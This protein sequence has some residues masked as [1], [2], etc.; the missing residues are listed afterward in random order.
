MKNLTEKIKEIIKKNDL[1]QKNDHI[2][3]GVSGGP[4]SV[5]L[6][7]ILLTLS[8]EIDFTLSAVH[9]N[10]KYRPGAAEEDEA[11]VRTFCEKA[12]VPLKVVCE[13]MLE[14]AKAQNLTPEEAGRKIRYKAFMDEAHVMASEAKQSSIK[15]AVAHNKNDQAE[16]VLMRILRGTGTDG[17][18]GIP[19]R[20]TDESGYEIIRPLLYTSRTEIEE[21]C[22]EN[23]LSPRHD[24]TNDSPDYH[25]NLIRLKLIPEIEKI[26]GQNPTEALSRLAEN[27][28][29]DKDYFETET[30]VILRSSFVI[31]A[32]EPESLTNCPL[33]I[34]GQARNDKSITLSLKTLQ[35]LHP[36]VLQRTI[37]KAFA[38]AGL[39]E[40]ITWPHLKAAET[41]IKKGETGKQTDF[42]NGYTLKI[43][44]N[45]VII[46][47]PTDRGTVLLSAVCH[48]PPTCHPRA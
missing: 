12:K 41:L 7:H 28:A 22:K 31:P 2:I 25:R 26:T 5:C 13:N 3:V 18:A 45:D 9:I 34:A 46:E 35:S 23:N 1:I 11:Y 24:K 33:E 8:K 4:D 19:L 47:P 29:E 44:Y 21:Y 39:K 6:F 10:H 30:A 15:I 27:A 32:S 36:A 20:R 42:P 14:V 16:T 38:E 37:K 48:P 17:L 40:D 43:S